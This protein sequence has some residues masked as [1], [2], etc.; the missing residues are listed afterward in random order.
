M[1]EDPHKKLDE[2][3]KELKVALEE[4][5]LETEVRDPY[6]E[7]SA[8][9]WSALKDHI[10]LQI[11]QTETLEEVFGLINFLLLNKIVD[12]TF[13]KPTVMSSVYN[14]TLEGA[15]RQLSDALTTAKIS[16]LPNYPFFPEKKHLR[17]LASMLLN[18][19]REHL[20]MPVMK[21]IKMIAQQID[22]KTRKLV[23]P[24]NLE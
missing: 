21:S 8:S 3:S 10:L 6:K 4:D 17:I 24:S 16:T 9:S 12:R 1:S 23:K 5:E 18:T 13:V 11:K 15:I 20:P 22:D 14:V 7:K 2:L 19:I